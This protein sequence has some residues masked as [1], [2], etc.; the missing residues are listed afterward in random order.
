[1]ST[2]ELVQALVTY[3][4]QGRA[5]DALREFYADGVSMRGAPCPPM[6]G[7]QGADLLGADVRTVHE[8]RVAGFVVNGDTAAINWIF[9]FTDERGTR[10][11]LDEIALQTW[12]DGRVV[13]ERCV[14]YP[15]LFTTT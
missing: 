10:H 14:N 1:M 13:R 9:D 5:A 4:E 7:A 8:H 2:R 12:Q 11:R 3:V 15:N 6:V